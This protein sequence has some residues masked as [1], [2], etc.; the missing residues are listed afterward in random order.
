V[1]S[2]GGNN[3]KNK[4]THDENV[5]E[6]SEDAVWIRALRYLDILLLSSPYGFSARLTK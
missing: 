2:V 4:K 6:W 1:N 3:K 5:V